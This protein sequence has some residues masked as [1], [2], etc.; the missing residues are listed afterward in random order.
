MAN[1]KI[2]VVEDNPVNMELVTDLL[3]LAGFSYAMA[4]TAEEGIHLAESEHPT[5]ILMDI[6]LPGMDGLEATR[7]LKSNP[8]TQQ[9]PIVA[10]TA[11]AMK[12]DEERALQ[13]GCLGYITK[14]INT[15]AFARLVEEFIESHATVPLLL[16]EEPLPV[17]LELVQHQPLPDEPLPLAL[18]ALPLE[19]APTT[20]V[21]ATATRPSPKRRKR[22]LNFASAPASSARFL[23]VD[24]DEINR[25][26]LSA[27]LRTLGYD[28]DVVSSGAEALA[29]LNQ[30]HDL[31]LLDY[32]M[33]GLDGVAVCQQVR[34][35][36]RFPDIPIIMVT[37]L[38]GKEDQ[39]RAV[40]AGANDWI[41]KPVDRT[42]LSVRVG[43]LLKMKRATDALRQQQRD[44]EEVVR[45]RTQELRRAL[46]EVRQAQSESRQAA[47]DAMQRMAY[48][49]EFR[50]GATAAA[51]IRAVGQYSAVIALSLGLSPMEAE[52]VLYASQVHDIGL[53]AIQEGIVNKKG[54]RDDYEES[55][56]RQHVILGARLLSGSP[57]E[58]LRAA[59]LIALTHHERWDGK[60]YPQGLTGEEIPLFGRIV[61]LAD[62][63]D[64]WTSYNHKRRAISNDEA[65]VR[66]Q[67]EAGKAFDPAV[68]DAFLKSF[69]EIVEW[70]RRF[71]RADEPPDDLPLN[72]ISFAV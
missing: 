25:E 31:I 46:D 39:L 28:S 7:Q 45:S 61:A 35:E 4:M 36:S 50:E 13:A 71:R 51:H 60:G 22:E 43:S 52:R 58:L 56:Y 29:T 38:S 32:M 67:E 59:E 12:G 14:P 24:D 42:E 1:K 9:I 65:C 41:C 5:L 49:A 2:L 70:Q 55:V 30:H 27:M 40:E 17:V 6:Q 63:F 54:E 62:T 15:R 33:P 72:A 26:M 44:L 34:Q 19:V 66:L 3:E 11:H 8:T 20:P 23:I 69:D 37:A 57:S 16:E 68:V 18:E 21:A 53:L 64:Q 10:L 47:L 48:T